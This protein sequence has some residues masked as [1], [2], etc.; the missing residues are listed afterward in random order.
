MLQT[1]KSAIFLLLLSSVI[2]GCDSTPKKEKSEPEQKAPQV[3]VAEKKP[4]RKIQ[5]LNDENAASELAWYGS[6]NPET[7]VLLKTRLGNIKIRLYEETPLHRANFVMLTKRGYYDNS[8]FYR[9]MKDFVVQGGDSDEYKFGKKKKNFGKYTVPAELQP[10]KFFHKRGAVAMAREIKQNP[11]KR[12]SSYDFYI[13][14]GTKQ[15]EDDLLGF[16]V[17]DLTKSYPQ[18]VRKVYKSIGGVPGLDGDFTVF[19]EVVEG[20]DVVEK[21]EKVE[22]SEGDHWPMKDILI[23]AEVLPSAQ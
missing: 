16:E 5:K 7:E 8:Q 18:H 14:L 9:V 23:D 15:T 2:A 20:M 12:S 10:S 13:I 19:G 6:E 21:I 1:I 17:S 11:E 4:V 22:V 3:K